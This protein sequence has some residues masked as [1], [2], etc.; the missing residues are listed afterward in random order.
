MA[1]GWMVCAGLIY[2]LIPPLDFVSSL[3]V[4]A[5]LTPTDPILA[6]AVVGGKYA[7][8]HVPEHLRHLLYAESGC[9]DGAAFPF[10]FIALYLILEADDRVAVEKWFYITWACK[11][12]RNKVNLAHPLSD[13]IALGIAIGALIGWGFRHLLKFC[14]DHDFIDRQS[15]VAQYISLAL[16]SNGITALLGSDDLLAAFASGTAFAWDSHF[17][18]QTANSVFSSVIDLL[19]NVAVFVYIGAWMPF[20]A[21]NSEVTGVTVWRLIVLAILIIL[22]RRLPIMLILYKWIPDVRTFREALFSGHFGPSKFLRRYEG[23]T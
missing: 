19:F 15:Y 1:I 5:C 22:L 16:L 20:D 21:F 10:L 11:C 6:A 14:E 2:A 12:F 4:A 23:T 7:E 3:A 8:K 9:N 17:N 18:E 13:E